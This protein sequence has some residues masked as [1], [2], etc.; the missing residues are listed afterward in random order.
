MH[1]QFQSLHE[2]WIVH[3]EL[4]LLVESIYWHV[5]KYIQTVKALAFIRVSLEIDADR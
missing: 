4:R 2:D 5:F 1:T 3:S